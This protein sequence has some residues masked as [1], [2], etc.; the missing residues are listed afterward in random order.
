MQS[1]W[2]WKTINESI[3]HTWGVEGTPWGDNREFKICG[4]FSGVL[5][6]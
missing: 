6:F 4:A 1:D 2:L 5:L 3:S